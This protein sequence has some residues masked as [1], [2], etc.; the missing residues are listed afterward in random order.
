MIWRFV[1]GRWM[2]DLGMAR[3]RVGGL[4]G[5]VGSLGLVGL[6]GQGR[7]V[8]AVGA[9]AR[10]RWLRMLRPRLPRAD[11]ALPFAPGF[12]LARERRLVGQGMT[13]LAV[14]RPAGADLRPSRSGGDTRR[15]GLCRAGEKSSIGR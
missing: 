14:M 7:E 15:T 6:G 11:R 4:V 1:V 13:G 3:L 5:L 8:Q 10:E 12:P 9:T 2:F